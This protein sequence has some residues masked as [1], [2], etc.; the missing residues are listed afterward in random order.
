MLPVPVYTTPKCS[1]PLTPLLAVNSVFQLKAF[2]VGGRNSC[3]K[4]IS[5][6]SPP[7]DVTADADR[8]AGAGWE[9]TGAEKREKVTLNTN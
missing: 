8:R 5:S 3:Q 1:N 4:R 7:P 2:P 6:T 9:F